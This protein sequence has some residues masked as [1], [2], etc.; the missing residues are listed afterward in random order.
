MSIKFCISFCDHF[1][2]QHC[3]FNSVN[4]FV[5]PQKLK[6]NSVNHFVKPQKLKF[7]SVNHF[8]KPQKLKY[9]SVNHFVKPQKLKF[10]PVHLLKEFEVCSYG[11]LT[12]M[13]AMSIQ[14]T[15]VTSKSKG[16]SEIL[17]IH[18]STYQFCRT[19]EQINSHISQMNV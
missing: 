13:A 3:S 9:N 16:L 18:T 7:N 2:V 10:S 6:F 14:S 4:H 1:A 12:K 17:D 15:L 5:K 11:S 8:V 19:E